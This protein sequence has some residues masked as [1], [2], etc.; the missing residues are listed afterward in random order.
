MIE[1]LTKDELLSLIN[2]YNNYI[3][4]ANDILMIGNQSA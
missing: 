4:D 3:Q 2:I 1:K